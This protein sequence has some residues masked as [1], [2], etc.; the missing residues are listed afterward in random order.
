M[1]DWSS[2]MHF[3]GYVNILAEVMLSKDKEPLSCELSKSIR[4]WSWSLHGYLLP[5]VAQ[6]AQ[7]HG[8]MEESCIQKNNCSVSEETSVA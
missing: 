6:V 1:A 5:S 7:R 4:L 3:D 8:L 2:R